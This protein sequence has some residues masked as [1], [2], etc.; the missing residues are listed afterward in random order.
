METKAPDEKPTTRDVWMRGLFMIL[1]KIARGLVF[2]SWTSSQ[3]FLWLF[4]AHEPNQPSPGLAT[5]SARGS[6]IWPLLHLHRRKA[7]PWRPCL[8]VTAPSRLDPILN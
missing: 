2:G 8:H 3:E 1:F 5:P 6:R 4:F 7:F